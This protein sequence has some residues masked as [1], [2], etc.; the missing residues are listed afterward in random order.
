MPF[1]AARFT[2]SVSKWLFFLVGFSTFLPIGMSY[3]FILCLGLLLATSS[4][5]R[6]SRT[7]VSNSW[8]WYFLL[9]L[10]WPAFTMIF[11]WHDDSLVRWWHCWR[12]A[13]I[14]WLALT[15]TLHE[16]N[17]LIQGFASGAIYAIAV[18][19]THEYLMTLPEWV[20]WHQLLSVTGNASS[21]KWVMLAAAIGIVLNF[22]FSSER[23]E[24]QRITLS[25]IALLLVWMVFAFSISRNSYLVAAAM[26][27]ALLTYHI[28]K[29]RLWPLIVPLALTLGMLIIHL[30]PQA[31]LRFYLAWNEFQSF[32]ETGDLDGSVNV[33]TQMLLTAWH[34]M[35]EHP[36]VG[37]GLGSWQEIWHQV[38]ARYPEMAKQNN[39]HNDFLLWGMETGILGLMLVVALLVRLGRDA[40]IQSNLSGGVAW[41]L[42]WALTITSLVNAPLRDNSLGLS[43]LLLTVAYSNPKLAS[44]RQGGYL[45]RE[46]LN[47]SRV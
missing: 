18:V 12:V 9:F 6:Q 7:A 42:L 34:T 4:T 33:R 46:G 1:S 14:V 29:P 24:I 30:S 35:W 43:L 36:I 20:G 39:P 13:I 15:M 22:A 2:E 16:R 32:L 40:W 28:R 31:S 3:L 19:L 17:C 47:N 23:T 26:P 44:T 41:A 10:L 11:N 45:A 21:Q 5:Y 27:L 8:Y 37:A 38:S 25:L